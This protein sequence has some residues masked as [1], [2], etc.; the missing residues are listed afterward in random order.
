MEIP[1]DVIVFLGIFLGILG[2]TVFPYLQKT[3]RSNPDFAFQIRY[4]ITALIAAAITAVLVF[5]SFILPSGT[6]FQI[7][8]ASF[9]FAWG[10]NDMMNKLE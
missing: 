6:N 8:I 1:L 7:F 2:R 10:K 9:V 5:N 3:D 4:I